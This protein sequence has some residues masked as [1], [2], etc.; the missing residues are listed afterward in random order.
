MAIGCWG[1][2]NQVAPSTLYLGASA[3]SGVTSV[4]AQTVGVAGLRNYYYWVVANLPIG[5]TQAAM[6]QVGNAPN[7]LSGS[8]YVQV[9]WNL[10][11]ATSYDVLR[12]STPTLPNTCTCAVA[13]GNTTGSVNDT[14][15]GLSSYTVAPVGNASGT[16][17]L[18]NRNQAAPQLNISPN[19]NENLAQLQQLGDTIYGGI[20]GATTRLAGNITGQLYL[21]AQQGNGV[22]S[23]APEWIPIPL[24]NTL[25]YFMTNT[26]SAVANNLQLTPATYA[27]LTTVAYPLVS[28]TNVLQTWMTNAGVPGQAVLPAGEVLVHVHC[29]RSAAPV[30]T[31]SVMAVVN[32][33][34]STGNFIGTIGTTDSTGT[35][36]PTV[37]ETQFDLE[38]WMNNPYTF[39]TS[40]SRVQVVVE[41]VSNSATPTITLYY[42]G[43]ADAH[44]TLPTVSVNVNQLVPYTGAS[45]SVDLGAFAIK[46][47]QLN[48]NP[49]ATSQNGTSGTASC[50]ESMQGTFKI[51][52][53]YLNGYANTGVAQTYAYPTAFTT[54]PVLMEGGGSCGAQNPSTTASTLTLPANAGM[55]AETCN[56]VVM[57]Q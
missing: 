15:A 6:A 41:G 52:S 27:I 49:T 26:N 56:I 36:Q 25:T 33:V 54:G 7:T 20:G 42:G 16:I 37:G 48:S 21:L 44:I 1:Q 12:T 35:L 19:V 11:G 47:N 53:C 24:G 40:A 22:V 50:S 17:S 39:A 18:D 4:S 38:F 51:A 23:S 55:V 3:P 13:T 31:V 46:A 2:T 45:Q 30:G 32:E 8:N 14:G 5:Q 9:N 29:S 10:M 34:D 28:G 57:G 43:E